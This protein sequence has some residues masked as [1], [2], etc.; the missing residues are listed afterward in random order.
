MMTEWG[1]VDKDGRLVIPAELARAFG[2]KPGAKFIISED[3]SVIRINRSVSQLNRIYLEITNQCNLSCAMCIRRT[4]HE[5]VGFMSDETFA[6]LETTLR[7]IEPKPSVCLSGLGEPLFHPK[8]VEWVYR[9]KQVGASVEIIT[10]GTLLSR[11]RSKRLIEAGLDI[12]WFS[13]DAADPEQYRAIRSGAVW[14]QVIENIRN[15]KAL[16]PPSHKPKPQI[17]LVFV[18]MKSNIHE[19]PGVLELGRKLGAVHFIISNVYPYSAD[20]DKERLYVHSPKNIAYFKSP[21]IPVLRFPKMDFEAMEETQRGLQLALSGLW[22]L[23]FGGINLNQTCDRCP[24]I[25]R[26]AVVVGWDGWVSPC[27]V[28]LRSHTTYLHGKPRSV[29]AYHVGHLNALPL[30]EI[31]ES[32]DYVAFRE[33]VHAFSFSP[34]TFCGGCDLSEANEEDCLRNPFP[35]CGGCFWAQGVIQ[36]P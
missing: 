1:S 10:N 23:E 31:W 6:Q 20:M 32:P 33:R 27:V 13:I 21:W 24:F 7:D 22:N 28:L 25:E 5:P 35:T 36:C 16:R 17:G 2:L 12:L 26:G 4:W 19:L 11:E 9:L 18:A 3:Q 8:V 34:C 29:R 14:E 30:L 15:F